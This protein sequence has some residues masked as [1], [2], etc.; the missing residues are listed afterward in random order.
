NE[1]SS[2]LLY[3]ALV[4]EESVRVK[5]RVAEGMASRGWKVPEGLA[6]EVAEALPSGYAVRDGV[7]VRS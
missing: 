1:A 5:N 3:K 7:V 2:E 4:G 6:D